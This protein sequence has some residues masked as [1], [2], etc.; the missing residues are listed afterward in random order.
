MKRSELLSVTTFLQHYR[1]ISSIQRV[2]DN[3]L[4]IF[5]EGG[6]PLFVD[7]G[8][9]DSYMFCKED[10]KRSKVYN[11]PFDILLSKRFSNAKIE[12][13]VVEEGNRILR[14]CVLASS[15][16]KAIRTILQLEFTGRNTNAII[17]DE[18]EVVLEALRH[19]DAS[20]S[21]R[22]V[23]V[24]EVLEK[25]PP[26]ELK[27]KAFVLE[28]SIEDYL[29]E[30]YL[31]R[32]HVRLKSVKSQKLAQIQ[33]KIDKLSLMM[34]GLEN[35]DEL[36][37]QS[38]AINQDATLVLANLYLIK[39]YQQSVEVVDFEG[40]VRHVALPISAK[41]PQMAANMLFKKSKKLRQ[42]ALSL[43]LQKE[44]LEEKKLFLERLYDVV[45]SAKDEEEINILLPKQKKIRTKGEENLQYETFFL[46]GYKIM[47]GKNEKG[48]IALLK[49]A[50]KSD[51]WLHLKEMGS[52]H[53]IIRTEKQNV[54]E[55]ILLFA[56]KLCVNF[57]VTQKGGYLVD[58][59]PRK[60][61][62]PFDGANVAY[63]VYQTLR[64]FKE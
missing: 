48:N 49:E 20:V 26:R 34:K 3:V 15:S 60:N 52:T 46:E 29:K 35:E 5:F 54:P 50:K 57:S 41:T 30:A 55:A 61:V 42:K 18:N 62:K 4:K 19:I 16:Y 17:V 22:S 59:T 45:A 23:K 6:L 12:S 64:I 21:F 53:V 63:E 13:L 56:A 38:D 8:R 9:G 32:L 2:D 14:L 37:E 10:F 28:G 7:L 51:I 47:L 11:A 58:Y 43:H 40:N 1:K 31:Q 33:K 25:L 44:N 39:G 27:E 36:I 24:G